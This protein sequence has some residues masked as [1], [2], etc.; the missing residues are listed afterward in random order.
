MTYAAN[1]R[2][3]VEQSRTEVERTLTRYGAKK[4]V[5]LSEDGRAIVIFEAADRRIRFDLPLP[6]G[7]SQR[8]EKQ[9]RVRW[10]ALLLCIKAKLES[11][12]SKIETFEDAFLAHVVMPDG[13]TV[14]QHTREGIKQAYLGGSMQP[15]LPAPPKAKP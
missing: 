12:E 8:D 9:K 11:V 13:L 4:F 1:T 7:S 15:L 3:G 6:A 5:Y 2:V 14:G 10:R